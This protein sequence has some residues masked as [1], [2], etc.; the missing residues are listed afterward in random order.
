MLPLRLWRLW[1]GRTALWTIHTPEELAETERL[2]ALP[3]FEGFDPK[4][5]RHDEK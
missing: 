1:G 2:E 4:E 5:V 3:I